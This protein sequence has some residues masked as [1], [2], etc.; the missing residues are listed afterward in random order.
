MNFHLK[1]KPVTSLVPSLWSS[2]KAP[3]TLVSLPLPSRTAKK[4]PSF[5][6]KEQNEASTCRQ[7]TILPT[8]LRQPIT[9]QRSKFES[10]TIW[11]QPTAISLW[12]SAHNL[13]RQID[14]RYS[15]LSNS[16][17]PSCHRPRW[18]YHRMHQ[19]STETPKSQ[20][21]HHVSVHA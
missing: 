7:L 14:Y 3:T 4:S 2:Y 20:P 19:I 10:L 9:A 12:P 1:A 18:I 8:P 17:Q 5:T 15:D 11:A 13:R 16:N 21:R 6:K